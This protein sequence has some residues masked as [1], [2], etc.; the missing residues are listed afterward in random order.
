MIQSAKIYK[1][2]KDI[3]LSEIRDEIK[4]VHIIDERAINGEVFK[5]RTQVRRVK[6]L[7]QDKSLTGTLEYEELVALPQIDDKVKYFPRAREIDFSFISGSLY[8]IPF[9]RYD[10]AEI[11]ANK[12]NQMLFG[13]IPIIVKCFISHEMIEKFLGSNPNDIKS[14]NWNEL[15]IPGVDKARLGGADVGRSPNHD[16]FEDLGGRKRYI[17]LTLYENG[18][19]IALSAGGSIAFYTYVTRMEMLDFIRDKIFSLL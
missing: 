17:L 3:S 4:Q 8:F 19:I 7:E 18:W 10:I 14:C 13:N 15:T 2:E 1:I 11:A 16:R 6:W 9:A 12:I 5:L